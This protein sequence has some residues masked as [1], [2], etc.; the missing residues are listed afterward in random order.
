MTLLTVPTGAPA[1]LVAGDSAVWDDPG[2]SHPRYGSFASTDG[3][4]LTY[5]LI[6]PTAS[7][8][9]VAATQDN[10]WRTTLT[11]AQTTALKNDQTA[12]PDTIR[13]L[14]QVS[15]GADLV[16]V[17]DTTLQLAADP[18]TLTEG[19]QS[20]AVTM[21]ALVRTAIQDLV[22][23]GVK[24]AQIQGRAYTKN[25]LTE[26]RKLEAYYAAKV[27]QEANHGQFGY[28]IAGVFR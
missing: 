14:G 3:W 6:G 28:P 24:A 12:D 11:A 2:L 13:V 10:G 25:D 1:S 18:T 19:A 20:A 5:R 26:L 7:L 15:Q 27:A 17:L 8:E 21:L 23:R 4:V 16:T 22:V 9:V